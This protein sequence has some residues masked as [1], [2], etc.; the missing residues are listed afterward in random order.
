VIGNH[1]CSLLAIVPLLAGIPLL[2]AQKPRLPVP[3]S[4]KNSVENFSRPLPIVNEPLHPWPRP[5]ALG[6]GLSAIQLACVAGLVYYAF[7]LPQRMRTT[8][9]E[10]S[11]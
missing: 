11:S 10:R 9:A 5:V 4:T 1:H 8:T 3:G 2:H 7:V 6:V